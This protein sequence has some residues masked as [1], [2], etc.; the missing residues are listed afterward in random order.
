M[1]DL[2]LRLELLK[3][4]IQEKMERLKINLKIK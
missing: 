2:L 1:E 3:I 4:K